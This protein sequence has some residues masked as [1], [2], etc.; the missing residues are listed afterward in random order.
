MCSPLLAHLSL[1][2][3]FLS[4]SPSSSPFL[5]GGWHPVP[6]GGSH[7]QILRTPGTSDSVSPSEYSELPYVRQEGV[8]CCKETASLAGTGLRRPAAYGLVVSA[9][10]LCA[11]IGVGVRGRRGS[12][13][14][15]FLCDDTCSLGGHRCQGREEV[16]S[17]GSSQPRASL[18][19]SP[20]GVF[21]HKGKSN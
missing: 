5:P 2:T 20:T 17:Q 11:S 21:N 6:L 13:G 19:V 9:V 12:E 3:H 14:L 15:L 8:S 7:E 16:G 10:A 1:P 4:L 18:A